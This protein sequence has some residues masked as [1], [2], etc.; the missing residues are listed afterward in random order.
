[1]KARTLGVHL[2]ADITDMIERRAAANGSTK[3]KFAAMIFAKWK[4]DKYPAISTVDSTARAMVF[5]SMADTRSRAL[6]SEHVAAHSDELD[7]TGG[8]TPS[9][10]TDNSPNL[11]NKRGKIRH[12]KV[13]GR[14]A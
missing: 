8:K 12:G 6:N 7:T 11:K 4:A 2:S 1:M 5:Q 9:L 14:A 10:K 13:K 3:S